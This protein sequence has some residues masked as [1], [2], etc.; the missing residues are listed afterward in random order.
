LARRVA[1]P[2]KGG[3]AKSSVAIDFYHFR[4]FESLAIA[5]ACRLSFTALRQSY[6]TARTVAQRSPPSLCFGEAGNLPCNPTHCHASAIN[7]SGPP[8]LVLADIP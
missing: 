5:T 6:A 8:S 2:A 3:I 1:S 4:F 7:P